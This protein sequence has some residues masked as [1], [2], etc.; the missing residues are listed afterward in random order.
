[1]TITSPGTAFVETRIQ[2]ITVIPLAVRLVQCI[3]NILHSEQ[4]IYLL[5]LP[6]NSTAQIYRRTLKFSVK[7]EKGLIHVAALPVDEK[8][9]SKPDW[10][11]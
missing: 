5:S 6:L 3:S 1:M 4:K 2:F 10:F 11:A 9:T 8:E 7:L